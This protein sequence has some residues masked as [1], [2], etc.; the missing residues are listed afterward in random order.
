MDAIARNIIKSYGYEKYFSHGLG[1]S[2]G[3]EIHE[4]PRLSVSST[5]VLELGDVVTVE[6]GIYMDGLGGMRIEDDYIVEK[7]QGI[8]LSSGPDKELRVING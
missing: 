7:D 5:D 2:I 6:P 1:H 4:E 3:L 8:C